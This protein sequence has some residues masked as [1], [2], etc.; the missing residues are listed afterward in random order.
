MDTVTPSLEGF[1]KVLNSLVAATGASGVDRDWL[2][3]SIATCSEKLRILRHIKA[4][5]PSGQPRVLDVGAQNGVLSCYAQEVG[6][7]ASAVDY[8]KYASTY[9]AA[10]RSQGVDYRECDVGVNPLP[11]ETDSFD[12]VTY[13]DVIEHHSFSPKRVLEEVHRVL[14][15]GGQLIVTTPNHASIYNRLQLLF[16]QSVNDSFDYYFD[17]CAPLP[18]YP[19][20]HREYTRKELTAALQ[21]TGFDVRECR[22]IDEDLPSLFRSMRHRGFGPSELL[23]QRRPIIIRTLGA[24]WSTLRLPLGRVLWAV[25]EKKQAS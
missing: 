8:P 24:V 25:G 3:D 12:F 6:C 17:A 4:R 20:H 9:G 14:A 7:R 16:G 1:E 13:T 5:S 22:V 15:P 11:F 23:R 2:L 10:A 21:R 18:V 19:G